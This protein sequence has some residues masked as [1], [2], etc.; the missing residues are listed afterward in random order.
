MKVGRTTL[1]RSMPGRSCF[2]R[3]QIRPLF[4]SDTVSTWDA[5]PAWSNT[6]NTKTHIHQQR[7]TGGSVVKDIQYGSKCDSGLVYWSLPLKIISNGDVM[8][9]FHTLSDPQI[10]FRAIFAENYT[11]RWKKMRVGENDWIYKHRC[12]LAVMNSIA[13]YVFNFFLDYTAHL[14]QHIRII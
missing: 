13:N 6:Y 12:Y 9:F 5:S 10:I 8:I 11:W 7:H 1:D 2:S 14:T 3:L 4:S